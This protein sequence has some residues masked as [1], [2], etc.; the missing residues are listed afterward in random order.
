MMGTWPG[1]VMVRTDG[2]KRPDPGCI[3]K[4]DLV[5]LLMDCMLGGVTEELK[6]TNN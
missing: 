6:M 4:A 2:E 3:L 1:K 5:G